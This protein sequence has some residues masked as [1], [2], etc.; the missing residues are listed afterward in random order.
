M[1][2]AAS[3]GYPEAWGGVKGRAF[4]AQCSEQR[5]WRKASRPV[6]QGKS[7]GL[8]L[9]GSGLGLWLPVHLQLPCVPVSVQRQDVGGPPS[10]APLHA[11]G[12]V[13]T[14]QATRANVGSYLGCT[15]AGKG[16]AASWVLSLA[17]SGEA[18]SFLEADQHGP[19]VTSPLS[20]WCL[21]SDQSVPEPCWWVN[22]LR[23]TSI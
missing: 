3:W 23:I 19:P 14:H 7:S 4:K 21:H 12:G 5:G 16:V 9:W 8:W 6:C 11:G 2:P 17:A 1:W 10:A 18:R 13:L 22:I 15:Q 20:V